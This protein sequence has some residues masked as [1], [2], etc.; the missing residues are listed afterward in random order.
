MKTKIFNAWTGLMERFLKDISTE[1][2]S[3][4]D[5]ST[6]LDMEGPKM[7][8][9]FQKEYFEKNKSKYFQ[10]ID[11]YPPPVKI[12]LAY[13]QIAYGFDKIFERLVSQFPSLK[14]DASNEKYASF[15][16]ACLGETFL[17]YIAA[18]A[19]IT[20]LMVK[21]NETNKLKN[22]ETTIGFFESLESASRAAIESINEFCSMVQPVIPRGSSSPVMHKAKLEIVTNNDS[23]QDKESIL[24]IK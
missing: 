11:S 13:E 16:K 4:D 15:K 5:L 20:G 23:A 17:P 18:R 8:Q 9:G 6:W 19:T 2:V 24:Q 3:Y 7:F 22:L 12:D 10:D 1:T 21:V 14:T